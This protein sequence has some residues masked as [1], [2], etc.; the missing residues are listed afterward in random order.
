MSIP[1][2]YINKEPVFEKNDNSNPKLLS[3]KIFVTYANP[4][5]FDILYYLLK[6]LDLYT[7]IPI[8]VYIVNVHDKNIR[9]PEK[10]NYFI[11]KN[12]IPRYVNSNYHIWA[13]KFSIMID[14]IKNDKSNSKYIFLDADTIVNYSIEQLFSYSKKVKNIPYLSLHPNY[15]SAARSLYEIVPLNKNE[16]KELNKKWGHSNVIWYNKNCLTFFE[17]GLW[18]SKKHYGIGDE[19]II[20]YLQSKYNLCDNIHYMTPNFSLYKKYVNKEI[21]TKH[22]G[23]KK[24]GEVIEEISLHLFHGCKNHDKCNMI[25]NELQ[26]FN[27][28]NINHKIYYSILE[29][30]KI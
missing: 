5:Y 10:F 25:L 18:I 17:E 22:L 23:T 15:I 29:T 27:N 19:I 11:K 9:L 14:T 26:Q 6:S 8:I 13:S 12:V 2:K 1:T 16:N 21:I 30:Y 20:N 3:D 7:N 4:R 28:K 24:D